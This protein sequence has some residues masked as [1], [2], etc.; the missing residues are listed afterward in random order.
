MP[1]RFIAVPFPH[2]DQSQSSDNA[3]QVIAQINQL[4]LSIGNKLLVDFI[5]NSV[6]EGDQ[7]RG[8]KAR[9]CERGTPSLLKSTIK[10]ESKN[11]ILANMGDFVNAGSIS[12]WR[13]EIQWIRTG[14]EVK[15][16]GH[17]YEDR[18]PVPYQA[19]APK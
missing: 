1:F 16:T 9:R 13:E 15:D 2:P 5:E 6:G 4:H 19:R 11:S 18:G 7:G 10:Q 17:P 12:R 14:G 3:Y 8:A